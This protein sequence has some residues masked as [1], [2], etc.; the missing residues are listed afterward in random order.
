M[1]RS[2]A[3]FREGGPGVP[4]KALSRRAWVRG[5]S[6]AQAMVI[7]GFPTHELGMVRAPR[8]RRHTC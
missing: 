2:Q 8:T 1:Q 5:C 4:Q 6:C 3:S 7:A